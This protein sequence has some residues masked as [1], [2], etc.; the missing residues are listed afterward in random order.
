MQLT[1]KFKLERPARKSGGDRYAELV[2][3]N[4]PQMM[5]STYV[6]QSLSRESGNPAEFLTITISTET[7]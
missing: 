1:R 7:T 3:P 6:D 2:P 4:E 5:G